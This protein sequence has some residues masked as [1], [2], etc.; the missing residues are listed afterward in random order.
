MAL[1]NARDLLNFA[2]KQKFAIP[3]INVTDLNLL[4][5]I[6]QAAEICQ[7]PVILAISESQLNQFRFDCLMSAMEVSANKA[8]VPVAINLKHGC[9]LESITYGINTGCNSIGIANIDSS[10]EEKISNT[11]KITEMSHACGI[12]VEA[13]FDLQA[14]FSL[15]EMEVYV[16]DTQI[17]ALCLVNDESVELNGDVWLEGERLEKINK[18]IN[19]PLS[20]SINKIIDTARLR[21]T[22]QS[23]IA[24]VNLGQDLLFSDASNETVITKTLEN[25]IGLVGSGNQKEDTL[26]N[27]QTWSPVEHLIIFNVT[28]LTD[29]EAKAMMQKGKDLL[30]TIPGVRRVDIGYSVLAEAKFKFTWLVRFCHENVIA[31]YRDH[32]V[33]VA[34]ANDLFRPVAADRISI[35]YK[36]F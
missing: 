30:S 26:N 23:G 27:C 19:I 12:P 16:V 35:D 10:I 17:D 1:V 18:V 36:V 24:K 8:T 31:S 9:S 2:S 13:S 29:A 25:W 34:F 3:E 4:E 21:D 33:H 32:P 6:I 28:G 22:L 7:S 20:M 14:K 15:E 5:L 11:K